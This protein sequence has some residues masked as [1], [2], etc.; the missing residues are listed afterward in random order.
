MWVCVYSV[1]S[2]KKA[3]VLTIRR[4]DDN[5]NEDSINSVSNYFYFPVKFRSNWISTITL[6]WARMLNRT[7][8]SPWK[9]DVQPLHQIRIYYSYPGRIRTYEITEPNS[10]AL[11]RWATGQFCKTVT[12]RVLRSGFEPLNTSVKSCRL[13]PLVERSIYSWNRLDSNQ[14]P[15]DLQSDTLPAEL[16]FQLDREN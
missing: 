10:V 5:K 15:S 4:T 8:P 9:G 11:D 1:H 2:D 13:R 6:F 12:L 7:T 3:N 14:R 16:L